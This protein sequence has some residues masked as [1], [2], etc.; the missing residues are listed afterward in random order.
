LI[1]EAEL[2]CIYREACHRLDIPQI[3]IKV[4]NRKILAGL[5]ECCDAIAQMTAITV[6]IDKL[7]KIGWNGVQKELQQR[8]L[9]NEQIDFIQKYLSLK[10]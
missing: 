6:A 1:N 7:D 3:T 10:K 2:I 8:G 4:N 9:E 5:A